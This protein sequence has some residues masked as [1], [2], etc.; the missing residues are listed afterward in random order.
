MKPSLDHVITVNTNENIPST[1]S[2]L[3]AMNNSITSTLP[4]NSE[5]H[6]KSKL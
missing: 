1:S 4:V 3:T 5:V 6:L 2:S